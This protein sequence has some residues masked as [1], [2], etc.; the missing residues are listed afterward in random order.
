MNLLVNAAAVLD[1][2]ITQYCY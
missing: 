2:R 1:E